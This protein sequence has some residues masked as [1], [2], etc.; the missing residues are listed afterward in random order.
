MSYESK[1]IKEL[2]NWKQSDFKHRL[3]WKEIYDYLKQL[4]K[5]AHDEYLHQSIDNDIL[6]RKL[7]LKRVNKATVIPI[8]INDATRDKEDDELSKHLSTQELGKLLIIPKHGDII[9]DIKVSGYRND[10]VWFYHETE[11]LI[12]D[13]NW[14]PCGTIPYSFSWPKFHHKY[15]NDAIYGN[16]F[17]FD[18]S[19]YNFDCIKKQLTEN[20]KGNITSAYINGLK[21]FFKPHEEAESCDL[22]ITYFITRLEATEKESWLAMQYSVINGDKTISI[23]DPSHF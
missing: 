23:W 6:S 8:L 12:D 1:V 22:P 15:Y 16:T 13:L 18:F 21:Y 9:I 4:S 20:V 10:G 17:R 3:S 14:I 2:G 11:G 5:S 7:L 19:N